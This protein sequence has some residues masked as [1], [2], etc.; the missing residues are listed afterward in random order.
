MAW[1]KE[2]ALVGC[3]LI[4]LGCTSELASKYEDRYNKSALLE[5]IQV[6]L[7]DVKH[8]LHSYEVDL[9]IMEEK[10]QKQSSAVH[11]I[12]Q[13]KNSPKIASSSTDHLEKRIAAIR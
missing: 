4:F 8:T 6:E 1:K 11:S 10:L 12:E 9:R 2:F 7:A 13:Q 5:E 3:C